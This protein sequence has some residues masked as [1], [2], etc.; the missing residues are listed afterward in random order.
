MTTIYTL[1]VI[2]WDL[3]VRKEVDIACAD[4]DNLFDYVRLC[5]QEA[6]L[7]TLFIGLDLCVI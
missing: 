3:R 7:N 4:C 1:T 5:Y 2:M 6:Q